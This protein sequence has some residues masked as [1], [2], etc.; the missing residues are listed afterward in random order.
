[1]VRS[2]KLEVD[3]PGTYLQSQYDEFCDLLGG[4]EWKQVV[5]NSLLSGL[6]TDRHRILLSLAPRFSLSG[7]YL[8][9]EDKTGRYPLEVLW[10]KWNLFMGL[11]H[12]VK[13]I[14]TELHN[15]H[16]NIQ[17]AHVQVMFPNLTSDFL[18]VRWQFLVKLADS[19]PAAPYLEQNIPT[20]LAQR[21]YHVPQNP[22]GI[23]TARIMQER[24]LGYEETVTVLIRS[25]ERIREPGKG[26]VRGILE[27]QIISENI[28]PLE[29][30]EMDLFRVTLNLPDEHAVPIPF[31]ATKEASLERGLLLKGVTD[32]ID[33]SLWEIL[34]KARQS[35][36]S[37]SV[38][39]IFKT[40]QVPCDLY[41][42]GMMLLRTLLVNDGQDMP[43]VDQMAS[44]IVV[45]LEPM[46][47][48]LD[49]GDH[50]ILSSR[51]RERLREEDGIFP[52][53][54][55]L[56]RREEREAGCETLPDDIWY[57]AL[58]LAFRLVTWIPGFSF[59]KNH[60][61]YE[62]ENLHLPMEKVT[63]AVEQLAERIRTELFGS[64][65]R[66]REILEACDLVREELTKVEGG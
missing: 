53:N 15:P 26:S 27:T 60:G 18:P 12:R 50:K 30:S 28:R 52:K 61:D 29:Y 11:C 19:K 8:F 44:R 63:A 9:S 33:P 65:Q 36:F 16:L 25:M 24:P 39:A 62:K 17:P 47:Q 38:V 49:P 48:G 31:W 7:Q 4:A 43:S 20:E 51:L 34:E 66:N 64:R 14:H 41:S 1:M 56:Y 46:V 37:R 6:S 35:V 22:H 21:L 59:C 42:L 58:I 57:D 45:L 10:L 32:P 40:Y 23:Y 54:S 2:T 3:S 13:A 5:E 55:V